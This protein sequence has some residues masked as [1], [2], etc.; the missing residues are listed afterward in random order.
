MVQEI[1]RSE[2]SCSPKPVLRARAKVL[3][4]LEGGRGRVVLQVDGGG[5][6]VR[7][8]GRRKRKSLGRGRRGVKT[9]VSCRLLIFK[10]Q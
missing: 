2:Q 6:Q 8:R 3:A 10:R 7:E 5:N 9:S 4:P 1:K